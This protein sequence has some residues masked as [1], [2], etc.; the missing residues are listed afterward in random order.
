M[1]QLYVEE[2]NSFSPDL[3][4][5]YED[6]EDAQEKAQE[7]KQKDPS[8]RYTIEETNGGFNS[9]GDLLTSVVERG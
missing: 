5:E 2:E 1:Y 9:Y 6:L 3:I 4:G 8:I 7:L